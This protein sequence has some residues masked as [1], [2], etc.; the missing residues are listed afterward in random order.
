MADIGTVTGILGSIVGAVALIVSIKSYVRVAAMKSIDLRLELERSFSNLDVVL[1]GLDSYLEFVHQ[2]HVRVFSATGRNRSGEMKL[3]EEE[4]SSDKQRLQ[5][6]LGAQPKRAAT[7]AKFTLPQLEREIASLH[8]FHLQVAEL[9]KR[10]QGIFESDE[11]RR[12]EIR[13]GHQL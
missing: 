8:A 6:V 1:S 7:Y 9:R 12:K 13:A 4:F 2:S 5:R 3:F 11:E 10:Y